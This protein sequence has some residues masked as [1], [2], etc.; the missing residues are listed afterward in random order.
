MYMQQP[1]TPTFFSVWSD[2]SKPSAT[3][4]SSSFCRD[5]TYA[6]ARALISSTIFSSPSPAAARFSSKANHFLNRNRACLGLSFLLSSTLITAP[7]FLPRCRPRTR[8]NSRRTCS[9]SPALISR[10]RSTFHR[11]MRLGNEDNRP[12]NTVRPRS[13]SPFGERNSSCPNLVVVSM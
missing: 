3:H 9:V 1:E 2:S 12:S 7:P 6:A 10:S 4:S 5:L 13:M 8:S 11:S